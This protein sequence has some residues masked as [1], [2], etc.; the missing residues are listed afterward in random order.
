MHSAKRRFRAPLSGVK[1]GK[2]KEK[3]YNG[4]RRREIRFS[5]LQR[6]CGL[7]IRFGETSDVIRIS[8]A[9]LR[10][11]LL[12][13]PPAQ[14]FIASVVSVTQIVNLITD[15]DNGDDGGGYLLVHINGGCA[16]SR[17]RQ[18]SHQQSSK[19][20]KAQSSLE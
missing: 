7:H 15:G 2:S 16:S 17:S 19:P 12:P 9:S 5:A 11:L 8:A 4:E 6:R 13:V 3:S 18:S 14:T 20:E 1:K 10:D